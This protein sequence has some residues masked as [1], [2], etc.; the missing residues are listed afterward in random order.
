M[1]LST[2]NTASNIPF[3]VE[4]QILRADD[5]NALVSALMGELRQNRVYNIGVGIVNGLVPT[6]AANCTISVS[7]GFGISSDG[8]SFEVPACVFNYIRKADLTDCKFS[9]DECEQYK[10]LV[11]GESLYWELKEFEEGNPE[12]NI[13]NWR[14][15]TDFCAENVN[16]ELPNYCLLYFRCET[17]ER[18]TSCFNECEQKGADQFSETKALL[19]PE[20]IY[21]EIF[22]PVGGGSGESIDIKIEENPLICRFGVTS[23]ANPKCL[24]LCEIND[25][26]SFYRSYHLVCQTAVQ[27][28]VAA[29]DEAHQQFNLKLSATAT[30]PFANLQNWLDTTLLTNEYPTT[31]NIQVCADIQ[32]LYTYFRELILAFEAFKAEADGLS[33]IGMDGDE[34]GL[35]RCM[36]PKHL[37]LGRVNLN[38]PFV[39]TEACRTT[40]RLPDVFPETLERKELALALFDRMVA[41]TNEANIY[42]S[43]RGNPNIPSD[44]EPLR[45]TADI[46]RYPFLNSR[47]LPF[48]YNAG[49]LP[50]WKSPQSFHLNEGHFTPLDDNPLLFETEAYDFYRIEGH[51]GSELVGTTSDLERLRS[52]LNIAFDIQCVRLGSSFR[53]QDEFLHAQDLEDWFRNTRADIMCK[54]EEFQEFDPDKGYFFTDNLAEA[55][56]LHESLSTYTSLISIEKPVFLMEEGG[57]CCSFYIENEDV[58]LEEFLSIYAAGVLNIEQF[59]QG[60][61]GE[62]PRLDP[63]AGNHIRDAA[64]RFHKRWQEARLQKQFNCF[65]HSHPGLEHQGGVP[66]G[67]TFVLV[68]KEMLDRI[69]LENVVRPFLNNLDLTESQLENLSDEALI[70][71]AIEIG[72]DVDRF[73]RDEVVADF[74]LPYLCCGDQVIIRNEIK[75]VKGEITVVDTEVCFEP[76]ATDNDPVAVGV[77]PPGGTLVATAVDGTSDTYTN[78]AAQV[79]VNLDALLSDA[80]FVDGKTTVELVYT[81]PGGGQVS[82]AVL[83]YKRPVLD[84]AIEEMIK[85]H[86]HD[87]K[88]ILKGAL[89]QFTLASAVQVSELAELYLEQNGVAVIVIKDENGQVNEAY[90]NADGNFEEFEYVL[91]DHD[92]MLTMVAKNG[93]CIAECPILLPPYCVDEA[94]YSRYYE[95]NWD[96]EITTVIPNSVNNQDLINFTIPNDFGTDNAQAPFNTGFFAVQARPAGMNL[97]VAVE[98]VDNQFVPHDLA[99]YSIVPPPPPAEVNC[100]E[101]TRYYI[102]Y[103]KKVAG[104]YLDTLDETDRPFSIEQLNELGED[105]SPP[106]ETP[107]EDFRI[108]LRYRSNLAGC[109]DEPLN[110]MDF[111][112]IQPT[113]DVPKKEEEKEK[114]QPEVEPDIE[115]PETVQPINPEA[116]NTLNQRKA[117]LVERLNAVRDSGSGVANTAGFK[118]TTMFTM[119]PAELPQLSKEYAAALRPLLSSYSQ[120]QDKQRKKEVGEVITVLNIAY[121]DKLAA[122]PEAKPSDET[123][124]AMEN[125]FAKMKEAGI[126]PGKIKRSWKASDL[127]KVMDKDKINAINRSIKG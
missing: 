9:K 67:G 91:N 2:N 81:L 95:I 51:L 76:G 106:Y 28:I 57:D 100:N 86:T 58:Y 84:C 22:P 3:F 40:R 62:Y 55:E 101:D 14:K 53:P 52:C 124:A 88:C 13:G 116:A 89:A 4:N 20:S 68:Y 102:V 126:S 65:A 73:F 99:I 33:I 1:A 77:S 107:E 41:L 32:Y 105:E 87:D 70:A 113:V 34:S 23:D 47:A 127:R 96:S 35:L 110:I 83:V 42:L 24:N 75:Q 56:V 63:N 25:W 120:T 37:S 66:R 7:E 27:E 54:L 109:S 111:Q 31:P 122:S 93:P 44:Q 21:E 5:L 43:T 18:R 115:S 117:A 15:I 29:Y 121:L 119:A 50:S 98:M 72:V 64:L 10:A 19:V 69:S 8:Y 45:I 48:Y 74:C 82:S 59:I 49:I 103:D 16:D 17:E 94:E 108:R 79:D 61:E 26:P 97:E 92:Q 112:M 46:R 11:E 80:V 125:S 85:Q 6:V 118:R 114:G 78:A 123:L 104:T 38:E 12:I 39:D 71:L 36:F 30:N 60:T 90:L